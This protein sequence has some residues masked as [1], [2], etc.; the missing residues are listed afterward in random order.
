M[1]GAI[2]SS[3]RAGISDI[4]RIASGNNSAAAHGRS[5]ASFLCSRAK[6]SFAAAARNPQSEERTA[7]LL[8]LI[9]RQTAAR[10]RQA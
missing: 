3:R 8:R 10:D 9:E 6:S 7:F 5:G 4:L 1:L 2:A